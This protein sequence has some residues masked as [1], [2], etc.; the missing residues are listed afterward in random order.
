MQMKINSWFWKFG[1]MA[2]EQ[3]GYM[4]LEQLKDIPKKVWLHIKSPTSVNEYI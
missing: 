1:Y 4:A 2:L 3:F